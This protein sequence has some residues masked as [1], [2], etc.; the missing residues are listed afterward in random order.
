MKK[1]YLR[2]SE[3]PYAGEKRLPVNPVTP[4]AGS[5]SLNYLKRDKDKNFLN[6]N[7]TIMH[8]PI[9]KPSAIDFEKELKIVQRTLSH[10]THNQEQLAIFYGTGAPTKQWTPIID[11][12][13]DTYGV[14]PVYASR[15][16]AAVQMAINDTMIVVW[17]LK[18]KWDV[19]RPNQC[20]EEMETI[21]CTPRFP[22]YPSGH[23]SMSGCAEVVL[24]YFF[25]M[26]AKKLRKIAFDDAYSRLYAGVHFEVDNSEGLN[27]GRYIGNMIVD[28]LKTQKNEDGNSIDHPY[29][30]YRNANISPDDYKQVIHFDFKDDCTSRL[31]V[32]KS[33]ESKELMESIESIDPW[34]ESLESIEDQKSHQ[35]HIPR[36]SPWHF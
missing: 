6:P 27:L 34:M 14:S 10:L 28:H 1:N 29:R 31:K 30:E 36:K 33:K 9:K 7:G 26:E 3:V 5:W 19:A 18:Y 20:D 16:I 35:K 8:F 12:L 32:K 13:V 25:P 2:W 23:A 11:R 4:S 15:I 22:S 17:E 21:L 24:S